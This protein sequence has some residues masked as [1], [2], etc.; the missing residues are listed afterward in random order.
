MEDKVV[1]AG[2][3]LA[4]AAFGI[5]AYIFLKDVKEELE[6]KEVTIFDE[7]G[8][9]LSDNQREKFLR[10]SELLIQEAKEVLWNQKFE[11]INSLME[12]YLLNAIGYHYKNVSWEDFE[13]SLVPLNEFI[14]NNL[15]HFREKKEKVMKLY[16]DVIEIV[17]YSS[18][19][20][21]FENVQTH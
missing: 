16:D 7:F 6:E 21:E 4:G 10:K 13:D 14:Y 9:I 17:A 18:Q 2:V 12:T 11:K 19:S 3:V 20:K 15:R 8:S 1:V 5:G